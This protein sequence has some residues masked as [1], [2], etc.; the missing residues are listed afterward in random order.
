MKPRNV[1]FIKKDKRKRHVF[2]SC[3][4]VIIILACHHYE[5]TWRKA[6]GARL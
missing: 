3:Q 2:Y 4:K 1:K 6:N 5:V